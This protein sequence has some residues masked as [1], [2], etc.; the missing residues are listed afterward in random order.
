MSPGS[1]M[2]LLGNRKTAPLTEITNSLIAHLNYFPT[3]S[4]FS[5]SCIQ[6]HLANSIS[7]SASENLY[8]MSPSSNYSLNQKHSKKRGKAGTRLKSPSLANMSTAAQTRP[9]QSF[10]KQKLYRLNLTFYWTLQTLPSKEMFLNS[11]QMP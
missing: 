11:T 9:F 10:H 8:E 7:R 4:P 2:L 1:P 3:S 6:K 5:K